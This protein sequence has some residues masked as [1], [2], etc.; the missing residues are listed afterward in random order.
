[1]PPADRRGWTSS[2]PTATCSSGSRRSTPRDSRRCSMATL[3]ELLD[4][5]GAAPEG[6]QIAAF[7]DYDGT[8]IDPFSASAFYRH[9]IRHFEIGPVELAR[10]LLGAARGIDSGE[11]FEGV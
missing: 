10:T 11:D 3:D 7:F 4:T 6:P 1:M 8:V 5:V 9:R 2:S